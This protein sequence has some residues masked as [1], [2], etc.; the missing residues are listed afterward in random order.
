MTFPNPNIH[1]PHLAP[2]LVIKSSPEISAIKIALGIVAVLIALILGLLVL[3]VIG[4]ET[5]PVG[6]FLGL[7]VA[8]IPVPK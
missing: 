2:T 6:L 5:G 4:I 3:L 7:L 8:T 1:N